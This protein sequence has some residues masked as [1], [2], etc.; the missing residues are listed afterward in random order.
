MIISCDRD[1]DVWRKEGVGREWRWDQDKRERDENK[2]PT[3]VEKLA[4]LPS[5][6]RIR[7]GYSFSQSGPASSIVASSPS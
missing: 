7:H 5:V 6:T 2:G 1:Y 3:C 4:F